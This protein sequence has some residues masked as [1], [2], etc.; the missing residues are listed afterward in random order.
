METVPQSRDSDTKMNSPP[1]AT[2]DKPALHAC[3]QA[4][5]LLVGSPDRPMIALAQDTSVLQ[6]NAAFEALTGFASVESIG[7]KAP[8]L[9]WIKGREKCALRQLQAL[10]YDRTRKDVALFQKKDGETL[11][12]EMITSRVTDSLNKIIIVMTLQ[13]ITVR[14]MAEEEDAIMQRAERTLLSIE[15]QSRRAALLHKRLGRTAQD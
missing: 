4:E 2:T 8:H 14:K 15:R 1:P 5:E 13:D 12:V 6:V 9:W 11:W 7:T 3:G 10:L